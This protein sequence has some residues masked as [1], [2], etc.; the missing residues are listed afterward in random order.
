MIIQQKQIIFV[1]IVLL[2]FIHFPHSRLSANGA[3]S[4]SND[5]SVGTVLAIVIPITIVGTLSVLGLG[6]LAYKWMNAGKAGSYDLDY[7]EPT[8]VAVEDS[9]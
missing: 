6:Y 7:N 1:I 9:A 2:T 8:E 4:S 3:A 5:A